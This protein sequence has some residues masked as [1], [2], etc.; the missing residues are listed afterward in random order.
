M[1]SEERKT[2]VSAGMVDYLEA[3]LRLERSSRVARAMD[4]ADRMKVRR[5]SVT[6]ALKTLAGRGLINYTPYSYVTLT[7]AGRETAENAIRRYEILRE[8]FIGILRLR[9]EEAEANARRVEHA[10]DSTAVDKLVRFL[11]FTR[12]CPRT[13]SKWAEAFTRFCGRERR[14][15]DCATCLNASM[16]GAP[17]KEAG[18]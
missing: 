14:S 9:P 13:D 6:G 17:E 7:P 3:I 15:T 18:R 5:A 12:A 16:S 1:R 2:G 8:F 11:E 10:V 4:I